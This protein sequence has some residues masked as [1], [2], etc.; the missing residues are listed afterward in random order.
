M[1]LAYK[2]KALFV[3]ASVMWAL[4]VESIGDTYG[5]NIPLYMTGIQFRDAF[6]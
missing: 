2:D 1:K 3:N 6:E 5:N 4:L